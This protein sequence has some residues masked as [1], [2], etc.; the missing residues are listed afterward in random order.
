MPYKD[1]NDRKEYF[2]DY[3]TKHKDKFNRLQREAYKRNGGARHKTYKKYNITEEQFNQMVLDQNNSCTICFS[4]VSGG[5]GT[6][7]ID[8]DH[9][10]CPSAKSCGK[11]VRQLLCAQCNMMLG[12]ARES[13]DI[14]IA[15][16]EYLKR[17]KDRG[18]KE[19]SV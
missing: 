6:W 8:H 2:R 17:H 10:C 3:R 16:I 15:A 1:K 11:C 18:W 4:T 9:S 13:T 7:S 12:A 5:T 19:Y 14:L